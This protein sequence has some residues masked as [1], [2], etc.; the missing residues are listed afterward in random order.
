M[1]GAYSKD[2]STSNIDSLTETIKNV[3]YSEN[4]LGSEENIYL[5]L[6]QENSK[7]G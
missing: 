5:F 6:E 4:I 3:V 7:I 2:F 1:K